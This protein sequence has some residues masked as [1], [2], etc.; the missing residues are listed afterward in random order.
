MKAEQYFES[1]K[2]EKSARVR[3][4]I[5]HLDGRALQWH[6]HY[7]KSTGGLAVL[8]WVEYL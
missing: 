1:D 3:I 7:A 4:V 2:I 5:M 8:Q 6:Q